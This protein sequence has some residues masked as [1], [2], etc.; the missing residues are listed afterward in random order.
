M[1][2]AI[3][4]GAP[5][6]VG[7]GTLA[8]DGSQSAADELFGKSKWWGFPDMPEDLEYPAVPVP[9]EFD[10]PLTFICQIRCADLAPCDPAGQLPH[11]GMLYFFA[12]LD[13]F[14]GNLDAVSAPGLGEWET[15]YF[16]VLYS[17]VCTGLHT[18][19]VFYEDGSPACLP[20]RGISF[21]EAPDSCDAGG[22]FKLLGQPFYEEVSQELPGMIS[23][24][25]IDEN[26]DWGLRF[27]DCGML[28]FLISPTDLAARRWS[29]VRCW[30][31]SA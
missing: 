6:P 9:G 7:S 25:Q 8:T 19:S 27:F 4:F 18:H 5:A 24:L 29:A 14:L 26:D 11:K 23:L 13:Y 20:P 30:L 15:P 3:H 31:H 16:R 22:Y 17:P 10:D 2:I 1:A 12:S 28:N 21:A